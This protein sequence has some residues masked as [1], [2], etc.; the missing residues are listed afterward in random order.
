MVN[1]D[2]KI[3]FAKAQSGLATAIVQWAAIARL[4]HKR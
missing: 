2:S 4:R 1:R 3:D